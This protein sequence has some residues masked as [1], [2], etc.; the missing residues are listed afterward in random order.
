[1]PTKHGGRALKNASTAD[2]C[3]FRCN[4]ALPAAST[5]CSWKTRLAMSKPTVVIS[6]ADGSF[7]SLHSTA[8]AW[9]RCRQGSSTASGFAPLA[10]LTE[11]G[12]PPEC[13][14]VI[15]EALREACGPGPAFSR[16]REPPSRRM[17]D[18]VESKADRVVGIDASKAP[19]DHVGPDGTAFGCA[20]DPEG[21]ETSNS[22]LPICSARNR[23]EP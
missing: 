6:M 10:W 14:V 1:M 2:R 13:F 3:S 20:T 9:H 11:P 15:V 7:S 19:V 21:L 17:N 12:R 8:R 18:G 4:T 5:P 23:C 22:R 16:G